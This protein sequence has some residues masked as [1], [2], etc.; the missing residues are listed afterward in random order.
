[1]IKIDADI[2]Y[3][4]EETIVDTCILCSSSKENIHCNDWRQKRK[5]KNRGDI[6]HL[7]RH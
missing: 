4:T 3:L 7:I 5:G 6:E 2:K 1:M